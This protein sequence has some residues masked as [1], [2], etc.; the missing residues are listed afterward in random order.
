MNTFNETLTKSAALNARF[1]E[2]PTPPIDLEL[3]TAAGENDVAL[4]HDLISRGAD[5]MRQCGFPVETALFRAVQCQSIEA[6]EALLPLS[7]VDA[8]VAGDST[9][10]LYAARRGGFA[11]SKLLIEHGANAKIGDMFGSTCLHEAIFHE[12]V[13]LARLLAPHSDGLAAIENDKAS[14]LMLACHVRGHSKALALAQAVAPISNANQV[15]DRKR[16]ALMIAISSGH[17]EI[18]RL[19]APMTDL[20]MLDDNGR[21]ALDYAK[22]SPK[23]LEVIEERLRLLAEVEALNQCSLPAAPRPKAGL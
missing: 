14:P 5:P 15:D 16:N 18:A 10:L 19:L 23:T 12:E 17:A 6:I 8:I 2:I 13:E 9:C 4:I 21:S 3:M 1:A 20:S 11:I 22:E 7:D